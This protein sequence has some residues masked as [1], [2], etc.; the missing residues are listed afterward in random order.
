MTVS[1]PA[2]TAVR[3]RAVPVE[4]AAGRDTPGRDEQLPRVRFAYDPQTWKEIA[5]LLTNLPMSV[6]GF[7][8]VMT[9]LFTG[10]TLTLTVVG[11]PVLALGLLG[12]RLIGRFERCLLYTSPEPTRH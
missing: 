9:V 4:S 2:P 11:L 5:H 7:V 12:A 8:Y 1:K 10:A 6:V 3:P